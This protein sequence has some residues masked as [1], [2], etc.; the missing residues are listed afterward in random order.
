[1]K[2][3]ALGSYEQLM[4][5]LKRA[6]R[7]GAYGHAVHRHV[8]EPRRPARA[9]Q[10]RR[11]RRAVPV[12][13]PGSKPR[14]ASRRSARRS[15]PSCAT[16]SSLPDPRHPLSSTA[17]LAVLTGA[18]GANGHADNLVVH[19]ILTAA[20]VEYLGPMAAIVVRDQ[21]RD[22]ERAGREPVDVV[23]ALARLIDDTAG[24]AGLPHAGHRGTRRAA[25]SDLPARLL[26]EAPRPL[27]A[28]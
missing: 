10:R 6:V 25:A 15:S 17:V 5:E 14:A 7:R 20:L 24:A 4:A 18:G 22:A 11:R 8:R 19:N 26:S 13:R 28:R 21:L 16:S 1:M 27:S 2:G 3:D 12:C 9:A 23:D